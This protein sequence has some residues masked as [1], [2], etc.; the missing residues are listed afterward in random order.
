MFA[1]DLDLQKMKALFQPITFHSTLIQIEV[2]SPVGAQPTVRS[3][4]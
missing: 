2:L 3:H 4:T 1:P